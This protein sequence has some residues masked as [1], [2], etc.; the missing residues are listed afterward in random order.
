[1]VGVAVAIGTSIV[2]LPNAGLMGLLAGVLEAIPNFGPI[3]AAVPALLTALLRGSSWIAVS[4]LGFAVI[5]AG[6]YVVIQQLENNIL[7]PRIMGGR[8]RLHPVVVMIGLL[9][10][11]ILFG[12]VG[13][14]LAAPVTGTLA[15]L[16]RYLHAKLLGLDPFPEPVRP[17]VDDFRPGKIEAILFDLD[18]TLVETD[19]DAV[20][21]L[22]RRLRPL[23]RI[24][25]KRDPQLAARSLV[26]SFDRP[27]TRLLALLHYAHLDDNAAGLADRLY[28]LRGVRSVSAFRPVEGVVEMLRGLARTYRLAIVTN[29]SHR[30]AE[31]FLSQQGLADLFGVVTGREDTWHMKPHPAP[32]AQ[33]AKRLGV[34]LDRCLMV[35][36]T[37]SDIV[38]A[39]RAG[40]R[41]VG[42]LCG[43]GTRPMLEE[44]GADLVFDSTAALVELL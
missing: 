23:R 2:G 32:V 15:V 44:A 26:M 7:V 21:A 10:G 1:V 5:V 43:F 11:G 4:H 28:R 39:R 31:A 13:V 37:A 40:A 19:D 36:D 34:S 41:A 24:L 20:A 42:V 29:R 18:G 35:G 3:L 17:T 8:L 9:S 33:T 12:V 30:E 16:L 25:P 14:F 22:A 6:V 38:S 27:A